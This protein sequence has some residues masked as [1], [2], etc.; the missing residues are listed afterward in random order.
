RRLDDLG[1][2]RRLDAAADLGERLRA[3]AEAEHVVRVRQVGRLV[4]ER[5]VAVVEGE[6][7]VRHLLVRDLAA[8]DGAELRQREIPRLLEVLRLDPA[9]DEEEALRALD[10]RRRV[11]AEAGLLADVAEELRM[12]EGAEDPVHE[13][14]AEVAFILD[15]RRRA[16][17]HAEL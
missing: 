8:R 3:A 15:P 7:G 14:E 13:E 11:V 6:G 4:E 2:R 1:L 17:A 9:L 12:R 16:Q 5:L 10:R